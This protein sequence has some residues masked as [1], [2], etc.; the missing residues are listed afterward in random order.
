[1]AYQTV[2]KRYEYKY[3]LTKAQKETL[4]HAMAPHMTPD[5]YGRSVIRNLYFDTENYRLIRKSI[6]EGSAYK[7]KLRVR[8][9]KRAAPQSTVFVELKKKFDSVVY[10]RRLPLAEEDAV[11]WLQ[12]GVFPGEKTQIFRE[13]DY[14]LSF[15][16]TLRPVVFLS[17]EREAFFSPAGDFRITF[18]DTILCRR[19][20]LSLQSGVWGTPILD[21]DK[22]LME[23]KCAGG[24]PLWLVKALSD[25]K[26]Y[27]TSFS[28]YGTAYQKFIDSISQEGLIDA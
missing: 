12:S 11:R 4:L 3:L 21:E 9:Y 24:L 25:E 27:R 17:Y 26:L 28:K 14:F 23:V 5:A 13:I 2:F 1:M 10:K 6:E 22:V 8:C 20:E 19:A 7:E 15:Y 18:D 16:Q